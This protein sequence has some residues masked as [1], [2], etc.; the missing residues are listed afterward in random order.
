MTSLVNCAAFFFL[1]STCNNLESLRKRVSVV[2]FRLVH[3]VC[4][5]LSWLLID[6]GRFLLLWVSP[7]PWGLNYLRRN[8]I[9][10]S[11]QADQCWHP[12]FSSL[13]YGSDVNTHLSSCSTSSWLQQTMAW[14]YKPSKSFLS[15]TC[16][17]TVT[18]L[19]LEHQLSM[20]TQ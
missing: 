9:G 14:D 13:D 20:C 5:S 4:V 7:S 12:F 16:F 11:N 2:F 15:S 6:V 3:Y 18:G 8:S 10:W 1:M 19:K 17:I